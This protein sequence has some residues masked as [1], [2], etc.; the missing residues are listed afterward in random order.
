[1]CLYIDRFTRSLHLRGVKIK[2]NSRGAVSALLPYGRDDLRNLVARGLNVREYE[3][4]RLDFSGADL[5]MLKATGS[6]IRDTNFCAAKLRYAQLNRCDLRGACFVD[7]DLAHAC[8]AK[9][10]LRGADFS[11]ANLEGTI[12]GGAIVDETTLFDSPE[13][14]AH[15]TKVK[16]REPF[17]PRKKKYEPG[18]IARLMAEDPVIPPPGP[19]AVAKQMMKRAARLRCTHELD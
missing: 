15:V 4:S 1:M 3:L 6:V 12:F 10:D 7:A 8:L 18:R 17:I 11:R 9:S 19:T 5:M 14:F 16:E 13:F 2:R